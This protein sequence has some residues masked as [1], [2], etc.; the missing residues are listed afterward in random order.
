[1][2]YIQD[3]TGSELDELL[4]TV[5]KCQRLVIALNNAEDFTGVLEKV[6]SFGLP[7][8][9]PNLRI[10]SLMMVS[11]TIDQSTRPLSWL[12]FSGLVWRS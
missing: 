5:Q 8:H 11:T 10:I 7:D 9:A 2:R 1:M 12:K 3:V 4:Q 6:P